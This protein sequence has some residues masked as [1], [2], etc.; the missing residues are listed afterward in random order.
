M[1]TI[2]ETSV[3]VYNLVLEAVFRFEEAGLKLDVTTGVP[4]FMQSVLKFVKGYMT[5][6]QILYR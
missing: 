1:H 4:R 2:G 3:T 5:P 6:F